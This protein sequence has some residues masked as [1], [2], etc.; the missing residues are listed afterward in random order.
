MVMELHSQEMFAFA[1]RRFHAAPLNSTT[2]ED[3]RRHNS[4]TLGN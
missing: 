2:H 1:K 4:Q 3:R